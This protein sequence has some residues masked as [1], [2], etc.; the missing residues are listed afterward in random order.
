MAEE[1]A[2]LKG[3]GN[4]ALVGG[5]T[6]VLADT[7][8]LYYKTHSFHWNVVGE[9]FRSLHSLFDE[10]YT[11]LWQSTD[12]IAERIRQL[13]GAVPINLAALMKQA[14]LQETGQTPDD[15]AM[16]EELA[17]DNA[18]IVTHIYPVLKKA[19]ELHDQNTVDMLTTRIQEHEK[20]AWMLRSFLR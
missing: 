13:D 11:A 18:A 5:L 1:M 8:V 20:A 19:D 14:Q 17:N 7:F 15:R 4:K 10:Q 9:H 3:A 16:V 2:Y 12:V 6:A